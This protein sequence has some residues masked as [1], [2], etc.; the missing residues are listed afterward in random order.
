[1]SAWLLTLTATATIAVS[2]SGLPSLPLVD[3]GLLTTLFGLL[4][5]FLVLALFFFAIKL[6]QHSGEKKEN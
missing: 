1:M 6:M 5:T 3:K 2:N 4:G